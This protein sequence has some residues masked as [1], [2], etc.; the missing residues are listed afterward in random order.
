MAVIQGLSHLLLVLVGESWDHQ[1]QETLI[2]P[3]KTTTWTIVDMIF[4]N[5]FAEEIAV[6]FFNAL[7]KNN[8]DPI[9]T[10]KSVADKHLTS[11]DIE[12]F[13][14]PNFDRIY[15]F[16]PE[17]QIIL[18]TRQIIAVRRQLNTIGRSYLSSTVDRIRW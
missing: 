8:Y 18:P 7:W 9:K 3:W 2:D 15:A 13:A 17:S 4:A 1:T 5:P 16:K 6:E 10:F 12:D 14:T 11:Q